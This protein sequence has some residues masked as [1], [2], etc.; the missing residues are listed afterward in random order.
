MVPL[1]ASLHPAAGIILLGCTN[2]TPPHIKPIVAPQRAGKVQMSLLNTWAPRDLTPVCLLRLT[3]PC[4]AHKHSKHQKHSVWG[5]PGH[6]IVSCSCLL[7]ALFPLPS[8]PFSPWHPMYVPTYPLNSAKVC[9]LLGNLS[10][11]C[12]VIYA[13]PIELPT[14]LPQINI[15]LIYLFLLARGQEVHEPSKTVPKFHFVPSLPSLLECT[16]EHVI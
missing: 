7:H 6:I 10:W 11:S 12:R 15:F 3:H 9:L 16:L 14:A 4:L 13:S 5:L 2:K 1:L 8:M